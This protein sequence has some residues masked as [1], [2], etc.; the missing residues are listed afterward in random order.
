MTINSKN[1]L[2]IDVSELVWSWLKRWNTNLCD[3]VRFYAFLTVKPVGVKFDPGG[4]RVLVFAAILKK[5]KG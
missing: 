2:K 5:W 3:N 4:Q 1:K